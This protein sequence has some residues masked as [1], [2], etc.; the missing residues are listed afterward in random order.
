MGKNVWSPSC[1]LVSLALWRGYAK[2]HNTAFTA[3]SSANWNVSAFS[4]ALQLCLDLVGMENVM[5][6][7]TVKNF[8]H[9]LYVL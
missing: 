9:G 1:A 4:K 6:N 8:I 7:L 5:D 2:V 3:G